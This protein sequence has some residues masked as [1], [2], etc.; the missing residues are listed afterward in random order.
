MQV[1]GLDMPI[2]SAGEDLP[3][4]IVKASE[5][6]GG[7]RDGDVVVVASKVLATS[8]RRLVKLAEIKPSQRAKKLA[9]RTKLK[10]TF[11]ELVLREADVILGVARRAILTLKAGIPCANAGVDESNAPRGHVVLPVL[12]PDRAAV[13]IRKSLFEQTGAK[14]GVIIAD[15]IVRPLRLGTVGQAVGVAGIEPVEDC[16]GKRDLYGRTLRVTFRAIADQI[17]TAAELEMGE[18]GERVPVAIVR[19]AKIKPVERPKRSP[20]VS[21][22][23]CLYLASMKFSK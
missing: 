1:L 5:R 18:A 3:G 8:Q 9:E 19:G 10:P 13:Q 11:V 12:D 23:R 6:I 2:I 16:R 4:A 21:P 14:V 17:A 20:E 7:L 15:S 22:K